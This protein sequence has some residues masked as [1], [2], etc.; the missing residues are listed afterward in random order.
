MA[1]LPPI[2]FPSNVSFTAAIRVLNLHA[3]KLGPYLKPFNDCPTHKK[4]KFKLLN[5]AFKK[6]P[7]FGSESLQTHLQSLSYPYL[8][9]LPTEICLY[10]QNI[11]CCFLP[12][13]LCSCSPLGYSSLPIPLCPL[14]SMLIHTQSI[15][16]LPCLSHWLPFSIQFRHYVFK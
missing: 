14:I 15:S 7:W 11:P 3:I 4:M 8:V 13:C 1:S 16:T 5:M 2:F 10:V 9:F 12:M 6:L